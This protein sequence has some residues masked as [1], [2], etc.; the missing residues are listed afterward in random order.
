MSQDSRKNP[1]TSFKKG[2]IGLSKWVIKKLERQE[3]EMSTDSD[4]RYPEGIEYF[5][6]ATF[7]M[8]KEG[9]EEWQRTEGPNS[10]TWPNYMAFLSSGWYQDG[11]MAWR[12]T[13]WRDKAEFKNIYENVVRN[14]GSD[15]KIEWRTHVLLYFAGLTKETSG[16][17]IEFG[18]GKGWM[19]TAIAAS[20]LLHEADKKMYL[21]DTFA[22]EKVDQSSGTRLPGVT[23]PHYAIDPDSI[24]PLLLNDDRIICVVGDVRETL[25]PNL[26]RFQDVAFVHFDMNSSAAEEFCFRT[27]YP[28]LKKGCIIVLDDY[29]FVNLE[30]QQAAWDKLSDEFCFSILSL[31]TGQGIILI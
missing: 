22:P 16:V 20:G 12:N 19:A 11:L 23:D 4:N 13:A 10:L 5:R 8:Y 1:T 7:S 28:N 14:I 3:I 31:P 25:V 2:L 6:D 15:F 24:S 9:L 30:A 18:T 27:I 17:F 21:F 26:M 29:A